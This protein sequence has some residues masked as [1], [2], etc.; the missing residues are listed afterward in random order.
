MACKNVEHKSPRAGFIPLLLVSAALFCVVSPVVAFNPNFTP[1]FN[2]NGG[3]QGTDYIHYNTTT[4]LAEAVVPNT[5]PWELWWAS[6][7][8]GL[9]IFLISLYPSKNTDVLEAESVMSVIAWVPIAF[10][11][12]S[13]WAIDRIT[14]SGVTSQVAIAEAAKTI[15][16]HEYV[17]MEN[18]LI[19][20]EPIIGLLMAVFFMIAIVNTVR[21]L[22]LRK[23]LKGQVTTVE[24]KRGGIDE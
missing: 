1:I 16:S 12:Y 2:I 4:Q 9:L 13:S 18:H 11:S 15:Q 22:S 10:C 19:Y 5:T 24:Y 20:S 8:I 14:G 3:D 17:Y 21:L 6:G 23:E 7:L